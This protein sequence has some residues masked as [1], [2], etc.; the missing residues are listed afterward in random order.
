MLPAVYPCPDVVVILVHAIPS[1]LGT[2]LQYTAML[3]NVPIVENIRKIKKEKK[4][5]RK[6]I[7]CNYIRKTIFRCK[8]LHNRK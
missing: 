2:G 4:K 3:D 5:K 8:I 7:V 1:V 6:L